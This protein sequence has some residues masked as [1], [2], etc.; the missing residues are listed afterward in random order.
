MDQEKLTQFVDR[1][2]DGEVLPILTDYI[3]IPNKSPEF[4]K[5]WAAHG[6]MDRAV[7]LL[8][9]WARKTLAGFAGATLDVMRLPG[10]TP[11]IFIDIPATGGSGATVLLYGHLDKQPEMVGWA[12]GFGPWIPV[13]KDDKLYGRG[14][15]DDGYAIFAAL[16]AIAALHEQGIGHARCAVLIEASE[17]SGS[18]DL[19]AY[20]DH[21]APRIGTPSLVVCLDSG[22]AD[23]DQL[24]LTTSLR[25]LWNGTITIRVLEEGVHS[26]S[27]SGIV[28]SS[29]RILRQILS[30]IEDEATGA[31]LP[32]ELYAQIPADRIAQARAVA[33]A[34]GDKAAHAYPF[35]GGTR[36]MSDDPTELILNNTWRPQLAITGIEGLPLPENA[37]NVLLPF[38]KAS[39]SLRLPPTLDG[40][41]ARALLERTLTENAPYGAQ[42][43]L[44]VRAVNKGWNAPRLAPWLEKSLAAASQATFGRP[45][46]YLGEGGSIPFMAMLGERFPQTQFVITGVLG[47]QSNAHGPNEFLHIPTAKRVTA[48]VARVLADH[49]AQG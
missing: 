29:F 35:A 3:K 38:T 33:A 12:E 21:L 24:W 17:E 6:H 37:G 4:D 49:A 18:P 43:E 19:P 44:K 30:R 36:P 5:D 15:A 27:A 22:C 26:G 16:T 9:G 10:R 34:L 25:G 1:L 14:G 7:D 11:L 23:Y 39:L 31:I 46:A 20:M 41:K 42:V 2:W 13:R 48:A 40:E 32:P 28:P 45:A 47:P 8:A